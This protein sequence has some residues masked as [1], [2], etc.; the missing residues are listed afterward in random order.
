VNLQGQQEDA[1]EGYWMINL[2]NQSEED[3]IVLEKMARNQ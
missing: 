2:R 1:A 3:V